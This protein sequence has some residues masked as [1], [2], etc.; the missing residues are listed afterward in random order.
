MVGDPDLVIRREG[1]S[2]ARAPETLEWFFARASRL[3]PEVFL[4][5]VGR[6]VYDDHIPLLDAGIPA[7]VVIDLDYPFWHTVSDLPDQV[8]AASLGTVGTV[9]LSLVRDP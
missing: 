7:I 9:V 4:P 2:A 3:A 8:S 5:G 1:Y 6:A